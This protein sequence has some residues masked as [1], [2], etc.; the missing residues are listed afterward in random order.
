MALR[1]AYMR[2]E[3]HLTVTAVQAGPRL[4]RLPAS[5]FHRRVVWIVGLSIFFDFFDAAMAG[6]LVGGFLS[7]HWSTVRQNTLFLAATGVGGVVGNVAAGWFADRRGR[8]AALRAALG[9]VGIT[10]LVS[11]AA[12]SMT[13]IT[14]LRFISCVGIAAIPTIGFSTLAELMPPEARGRWNSLGGAL[15]NTATVCAAL[16]GYILLPA[17]GWRWMFVIPGVAC[18]A[19][20]LVVRRIPESP[21]WLEAVGRTAEAASTM[22]DIEREVATPLNGDLPPISAVHPSRSAPAEVTAAAEATPP[23]IIDS[24]WRGHRAR[25]LILAICLALGANAAVS[26]VLTWL[27][28]ILL[29]QGLTLSNTLGR[30][31][32]MTAGAPIGALLG[33]LFADR[34]G[35]RRGI[36]S[37]AVIAAALAALF[38]VSSSGGLSIVLGFALLTALAFLANVVYAVYLPELFPTTLRVQGAATAAAATK[39]AFIFLPFA[40]ASLLAQGGTVA[41]MGLIEGCLS[42]VAVSTLLLGAETAYKPLEVASSDS[43][44]HGG[45]RSELAH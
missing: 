18:L 24:L 5:R 7:S 42:L 33:A 23:E 25:R 19:L 41:A 1:L 13:L 22:E 26:T 35:R 43:P 29:S 8:R 31:L 40:M 36:A 2:H 39:F 34:L 6:A 4:D 17:G 28:T 15:A 30:T 12:P 9:L 45:S 10:T 38:S 14:V 3:Q 37:I 27:P 20:W 16:A 44:V 11:A 32:L 21:R